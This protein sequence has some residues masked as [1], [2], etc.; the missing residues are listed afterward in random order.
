MD[1]SLSLLVLPLSILLALRQESYSLTHSLTDFYIFLFHSCFLFSL[2][3]FFPSGPSLSVHLL[4][5]SVSPLLALPLG[6][7]FLFLS[8]TLSLS[9]Y[10]SKSYFPI[11][12]SPTRL[13][14]GT[15]PSRLSAMEASKR[16]TSLG[17]QK[18]S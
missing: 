14:I 1:L 11:H 8:S 5:Y 7:E 6:R 18:A 16:E 3:C 13:S 2:Y 15:S 4:L 10:P 12:R 9:L 17:S